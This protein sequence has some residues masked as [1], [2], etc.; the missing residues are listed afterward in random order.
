LSLIDPIKG[1]GPKV[2]ET[3]KVGHAA[4]S[5]D[6]QHI[7][8]VLPGPPYNRIRMVDLHGAREGKMT[9]SGAGYLTSLEWSAD[10]TGFFSGEANPTGDSLLYIE[11]TGTSHVLWTQSAGGFR[12]WGS[13]SPNGRYL[14]TF[15][16]NEIANV[17]MLENP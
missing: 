5:P 17:W 3:T 6:G 7:A 14:A 2:L 15:K 4:L 16:Y 11:R 10:G 9:V 13:P 12:L 8:F 1:R